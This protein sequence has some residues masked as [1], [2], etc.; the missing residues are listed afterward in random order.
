[1][2]HRSSVDYLRITGLV[3]TVGMLAAGL[4]CEADRSLPLVNEP[5]SSQT[6]SQNSP[7]HVNKRVLED[8]WVVAEAVSPVDDPAEQGWETEVVSSQV[9]QR[10]KQLSELIEASSASRPEFVSDSFAC[11]LLRPESLETVF[12]TESIAVRRWYSAENG[13]VETER[14]EAFLPALRKL[15]SHVDDLQNVRTKT[16][17]FGVELQSET[18]FIDLYFQLFGEHASGKLQVNATWRCVWSTGEQLELQSIEPLAYEEVVT[19]GDSSPLFADRTYAVLEGPVFQQQLQHGVDHWLDR[20]ELARGIDIGGW[21]GLAIADVNQ[22]GLDDLYVCQPGGLPN[23]LYVQNADGTATETSQAAGVDW[24]E[25]SHAALFVDLDNDSDQDLLVGVESGVLILSNDG[26]GTFKP[27]TS[28]V[29]PAALPYSLSAADVDVDGDLDAYVCC[30]NRRQGIN[31]HLLFA[32]PVPYHDANNGGRNVLL[33]NLATPPTG[34]WKFGYGTGRLGLDENNRKFSYA[35]AW[36]DYDNDGDLDLYVANDFGR[37]NLY[38]NQNGHFQDVAA[39]A[40]VEDIG[41]GMSTCWADYNNDGFV[42]LYVSN[43]FSSAGNRITQ[44]QQF[45]QKADD[46][47]RL[48]FRRHAR[49]NS[50]F[51]NSGDGRFEDVAVPA[52][53]VLGRWAWGS[54]FADLN[55]D[56]WQDLI[57]TNGFITQ[58]DSGDL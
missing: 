47:T 49:G 31:R 37:N 58:E 6:P 43:M 39:A 40:G 16:K 13:G 3:W 22:D 33:L 24:L 30:Y 11:P 18:A 53:V 10:L 42:D 9:D 48:A 14:S 55:H 27:R 20:V 21:Q 4:G 17:V 1:M 25:S 2:S 36:E 54:K 5:V 50:L 7:S 15:V 29:L 12:Q 26:H 41:P 28:M 34:A 8:S 45:Q 46:A 57:V 23:R 51:S 56:G 44:Q 19:T 32:R 35:A 52:G 38:Q